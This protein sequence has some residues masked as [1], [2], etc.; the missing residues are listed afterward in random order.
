MPK[1]RH[2]ASP[3]YAAWTY[4]TKLGENCVILRHIAS[5]PYAAWTYVKSARG[6]TL[7]SW[8]LWRHA[9]METSPPERRGEWSGSPAATRGGDHREWAENTASPTS[10]V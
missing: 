10:A 5:P 2:I 9:G 8:H 4:G 3:P 7:A 1:L 6:P